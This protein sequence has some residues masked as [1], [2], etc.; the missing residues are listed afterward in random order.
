MSAKKN[1]YV[2]EYFKLTLIIYIG[3]CKTVQ[4]FYQNLS[5]IIFYLTCN[6]T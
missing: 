6:L 3:L 1:K 2:N 5:K 4:Q